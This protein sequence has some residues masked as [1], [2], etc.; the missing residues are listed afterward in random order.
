[1]RLG[2]LDNGQKQTVCRWVK[3]VLAA[4][5]WK[6][7]RSGRVSAGNLAEVAG[8]IVKNGNSEGEARDMLA[9]LSLTVLPVD[10]ELGIEAGFMRAATDMAGLS[11]G[12][13]FCLALGRRLQAPVLTMDRQWMKIAERV[14]VEVKLLR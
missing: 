2:K 11:V 10:E 13:R 5:G 9:A 7:D 3:E 12:D 1:M 6:P 4:R 14:G 8:G